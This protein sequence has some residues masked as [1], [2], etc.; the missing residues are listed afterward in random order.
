[1]KYWENGFYLEQNKENSRIEITDEEWQ[2]LLNEQAKGKRIYFDK[3]EKIL[4]TEEIMPTEEDKRQ[5]RI[6]KIKE[7]LT[8]LSYD[9]VQ[10]IAGEYIEDIKE[11]KE[12][13][14]SLHNELREL[15]GKNKRL[16]KEESK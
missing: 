10:D 9:L 11:R 8:E 2:V 4:K 14:I 5:L 15:L 1:M 6:E 3:E 13:F 16:L 7:E 12:E